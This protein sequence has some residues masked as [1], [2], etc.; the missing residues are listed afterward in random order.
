MP[1][2]L[3]ELI[4]A[5]GAELEPDRD[6]TARAR[7]RAVAATPRPSTGVLRRLLRSRRGRVGAIAVALV[8]AGGGATATVSVIQ[9][10]GGGG[11]PYEPAPQNCFVLNGYEAGDPRLQDA[12][13]VD[14]AGGATTVWV[15]GPGVVTASD[16]DR[17]GGWG[18]PRALS[19]PAER[20][21][22][23]AALAG[24]A[25]GDL[26]V[27]WLRDEAVQVAVR[28]AGGPWSPPRTVSAPGR[29]AL[30][31][32]VQVAVGPS[33]RVAVTWLDVAASAVERSG[34][35]YGIRGPSAATVAVGDVGGDFADAAPVA[36]PGADRAFMAPAIGVDP[37]GTVLVALPGGRFGG[38]V[39]AELDAV[40]GT[41]RPGSRRELRLPAVPRAIGGGSSM[42]G[43]SLA[44]GPGGDAAVAWSANG[45]ATA[46]FRPAGG[47]W[48]R[49]RRISRRGAEAGEVRLAVGGDGRVVAAWPSVAVT[50]RPGRPGYRSRSVLAAV[51]EPRGGWGPASRLSGAGQLAGAPAVA[52]DGTGNATA[53]WTV[54]A[55]RASGVASRIDA[56]T[57]PRGSASWTATSTVSERG[58]G[59]LFPAVA[60]GGGGRRVV[61]WNRCETRGTGTVRA[62]VADPGSTW[63]APEAVFRP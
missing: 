22:Y 33:G 41:L 36:I 32:E 37:A 47:G 55:N 56:S 61:V 58:L 43:P 53:A 44:L 28:P 51:H 31:P 40:T 12:V 30:G 23:R 57:R 54:G 29:V 9:S 4:R 48:E 42:S 2:D 45:I 60:A 10:R 39:V 5:A 1:N 17:D 14:D 18:G 35:G 46:A 13:H 52:V 20:A 62:S 38:V 6:A 50:P 3:D 15:A 16:R 7:A 24:N 21:P 25:R 27:A 63:S 19:A 34:E 26:A 11:F 49:P 59:P 8:L